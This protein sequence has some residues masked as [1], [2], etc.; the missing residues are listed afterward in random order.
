MLHTELPDWSRY[1]YTGTEQIPPLT[2]SVA[3]PKIQHNLS[4]EKQEVLSKMFYECKKG[5]RVSE[6]RVVFGYCGKVFSGI[7]YSETNPRGKD[8]V[9]LYLNNEQWDEA[10]KN[11]K[12][13][14][15]KR[16][17]EW[18][19]GKDEP[20]G[21]DEW[22]EKWGNH[23]LVTGKDNLFVS[24]NAPIFIMSAFAPS[25]I[26]DFSSPLLIVNP[27]LHDY[28][29]YTHIDV[30]SLYQ[31]ITGYVGNVLTNREDCSINMTQELKRDSKGFDKFSFKKEKERR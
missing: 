3:E 9:S 2:K 11:D 10:L 13:Y 24:L 31:D 19:R 8:K 15:R 12:D 20:A 16:E 21:I 25:V 4:N 26:K 14:K 23:H 5:E 17:R 7:I 22:N 6:F 18:W 30:V 29:L 28:R 27:C 1:R